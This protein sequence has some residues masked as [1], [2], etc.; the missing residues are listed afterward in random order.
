MQDRKVLRII[1]CLIIF[2]LIYILPVLS[3]DRNKSVEYAKEYGIN[4]NTKIY[5]DYYKLG[6][7]DCT[8]FASQCLIAG[9]IV[10]SSTPPADTIDG[11]D[12][13]TKTCLIRAEDMPVALTNKKN[14]AIEL[15]R[16]DNITKDNINDDISDIISKG[17]KKGD[18]LFFLSPY[19]P[20]PNEQRE[21]RHSAII[22]KIIGNTYKD[23][24]CA[25]HGDPP[26]HS[27]EDDIRDSIARL[28]E[29]GFSTIRFIHVKDSPVV[30][31]VIISQDNIIKYSAFNRYNE[32]RI[33]IKGLKKR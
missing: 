18:Y 25:W 20:P 22:T 7:W 17:L 24:I 31:Q 15:A 32:E 23:I 3:Y 8:N 21:I 14:R 13:K 12:W 28:I 33:C 27:G 16:K 1:I 4:A 19:K 11:W 30:R 5:D 6:Y 26:Y 29:Q 10:F 9:G 2:W